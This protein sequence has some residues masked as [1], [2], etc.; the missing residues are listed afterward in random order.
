MIHFKISAVFTGKVGRTGVPLAPDIDWEKIAMK[1]ALTGGYIKHLGFWWGTGE[2]P[3][4]KW[5]L[6]LKGMPL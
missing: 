1:F 4:Q 2:P 3:P 6:Q 5:Q